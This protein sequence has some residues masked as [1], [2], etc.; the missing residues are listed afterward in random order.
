M[1][2]VIMTAA[3]IAMAA[4]KK[5]GQSDLG[6]WRRGGSFVGIWHHSR[7]RS[8][9]EVNEV[10]RESRRGYRATRHETGGTSMKSPARRGLHPTLGRKG[11]NARGGCQASQPGPQLLAACV[12]SLD[13]LAVTQGGPL[14]CLNQVAGWAWVSSA[15]F[16]TWATAARP[17]AV[18]VNSS[19]VSSSSSRTG[20][21]A[22]S[23]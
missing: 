12:D 11:R 13:G 15:T 3:A 21:R 6:G 23:V 20:V 5:I 2:S 14:P 4:S 7:V 22:T 9:A 10:C 8:L 1:T 18:L 17:P 19:S 16:L